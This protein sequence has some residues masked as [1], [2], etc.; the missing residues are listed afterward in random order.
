MSEEKNNLKQRLAAVSVS[1]NKEA[2]TRVASAWTLAKSLV[3]T[4]PADIQ[5][6]LASSLLNNETLVLTAAL[7]QTAVN[8]HYTKVAEKFEQI[9]K[10]E[11]N[12]LLE[13]ESFLNKIMNEVK[14]ELKGE[15][16]NAGAECKCGG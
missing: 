15:A 12:E 13:N 8:A 7:R 11:L 2:R 4:A 1:K 6:K 16:K 5:Y 9:H 10:V 14:S 3:P